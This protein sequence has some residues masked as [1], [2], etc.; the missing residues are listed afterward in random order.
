MNDERSNG[1]RAYGYEN[2]RENPDNNERRQLTKMS[3]V[4][5]T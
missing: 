3:D 4:T 1:Q 5:R 2:E